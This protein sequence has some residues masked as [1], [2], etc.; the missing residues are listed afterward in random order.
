MA[1][2]GA[3]V[4]AVVVRPAPEGQ[5]AFLATRRD[6]GPVRWN[7]CEPILYEVNLEGSPEGALDAVH[8]AIE[9][10]GTATG[11]DFVEVGTTDRTP[12]G[13]QAS[14][15]TGPWP[16]REL[17]PVLVSWVSAEAFREWAPPRRY[18]ALGLPRRMGLGAD[19]RYRSGMIVVNADA[20][21]LPGDRGPF[22]LEQVLMHEWGHVLGLGH[23]RS[24]DELMWSPEVAGAD[25]VP[26]LNQVDWGT[27]DLAGLEAVG[28]S[29]GCLPDAGG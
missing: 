20:R 22:S 1:A 7:P 17:L 10:V 27:G 11:I 8:T 3:A 25:E 16:D 13:T 12:Q 23:V 28:R 14:D 5:H 6:G 29:A 19:D 24:G 26:D 4:W 15:F 18:V 9:R 21:V 2:T